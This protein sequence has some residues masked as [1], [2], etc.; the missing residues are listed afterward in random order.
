MALPPTTWQQAI[1]RQAPLSWWETWQGDPNDDS[2]NGLT[3]LLFAAWSGD[4]RLMRLLLERGGDPH[5]TYQGKNLVQ[6]ATESQEPDAIL[7]SLSH[8]HDLTHPFGPGKSITAIT[9]PLGLK[10]YFL[11]ALSQERQHRA[12]EAVSIMDEALPKST[13]SREKER[14]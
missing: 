3:P 11:K 6:M 10:D 8:Y 12:E 14:F 4:S 2:H 9:R 1:S 7:F 5:R 13:G